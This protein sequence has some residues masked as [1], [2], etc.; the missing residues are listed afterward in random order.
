M[1]SNEENTFLKDI[2]NHLDNNDLSSEEITEVLR[3]KL[4]DLSEAF[5]NSKCIFRMTDSKI[6]TIASQKHYLL[7]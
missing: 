4:I 6:K 7:I 3:T 5:L 2:S 1:E